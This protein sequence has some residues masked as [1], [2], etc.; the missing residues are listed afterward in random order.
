MQAYLKSK[1]AQV[2]FVTIDTTYVLP[3]ALTKENKDDYDDNRKAVSILSEGLCRAENEC[4][5]DLD[6]AQKIWTY[7]EIAHEGNN[8][9]KARKFKT[10]RREH[11]NFVQLP[12]ESVDDLNQ[13]FLT[14]VNN[15]R[16]NITKF[17]YTDDERGLK[18]LHPLDRKVWSTKV[19]AII[20]SA[21]YET[22]TV[23]ELFSKLKST[24]VDLKS[25]ERLETLLLILIVWLSSQDLVLVL[26]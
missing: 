6:L 7:L 19:D 26:L 22:L 25:R 11:K 21:N 13:H 5:R 16:A 15:M 4:I 18:L 10:Y 2:W 1:G 3:D 24:E 17:P 8:H 9:V 12:G 23:D 14:I 20:E